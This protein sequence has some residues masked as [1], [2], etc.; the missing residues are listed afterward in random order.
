MWFPGVTLK[1]PCHSYVGVVISFM[2]NLAELN[3]K[4]PEHQVIRNTKEDNIRHCMDR[5]PIK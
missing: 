4:I 2:R 1:N 5:V 3:M